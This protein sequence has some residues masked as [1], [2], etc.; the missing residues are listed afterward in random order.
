MAAVVDFF[1]LSLLD[2]KRDD[3]NAV[4]SGKRD[5]RDKADLRVDIE[6]NPAITPQRAHREFRR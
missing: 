1:P 6:A 4:L 5:Q 2:R 3:Q